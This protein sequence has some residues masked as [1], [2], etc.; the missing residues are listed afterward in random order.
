MAH[1][2]T[3]SARRILSVACA[4]ALI[5]FAA[6]A[7]TGERAQAADGTL[8]TASVSIVTKSQ[9]GLLAARALTVRVR[10]NG[11]GIV[12]LSARA[13]RN[14]QFRSA[15]VS[16]RKAGTRLVRIRLTPRGRADLAACGSQRVRVGWKFRGQKGA[17]GRATSR[18]LSK[19]GQ[20]CFVK[21][22]LGPNPER[23]D[24]LDPSECLQPFANDYFTKADPGT[25]TGRRLN[26]H[27]ESTPA[28][29]K[30]QHIG[31]TDINRADGFSPG[32]MIILKIPGL[33]TPAAFQNS[34]LAPITDTSAWADPE[35]AVMVIDAETGK[36]HPI[37]AELDSNP[38]TIDP[39]DGV[40][41]G[42]NV[43]PSNTDEVNLI[44]RAAKN[45]EY[46]HRYIVA[47]RNL[48]DASGSPI[49]APLA[50][51]V[52][53]DNLPTKQPVVEGRRAHMDSL[54]KTLVNKAGVGRR[55][56]YMAWD[57]TVASRESITGRAL[58]I[59][60]NAFER[61]GDSN[62]SD[63]VISGNSP[64]F[65]ILAV[66]DKDVPPGPGCRGGINPPS[67]EDS[68]PSPGGDVQRVIEGRLLNVPC[69]LNQDGCPP[70]ATFEIKPD[71]TV[72]F[73]P[74]F[75]MRVPFRCFIPESIQPSGEGTPVSPGPA[76]TYGHGLLGDYRQITSAGPVNV[77]REGGGVW[78][79]ANWDGF[80]SA[81]LLTVIDSLADMSNFN[82]AVDRMQQGFVNF[83]MLGRAM[84]HPGGFGTDPAFQLDNL[85]GPGQNL[86]SAIDLSGGVNTRLQYMGISQGG[87][88]G[89]SL[90]ALTPDA[91]RGVLGVPGMNYSL[92]LR[93]SV[94]SDTY[95]K[96]PAFGL[97]KSYPN[98]RD[99]PMILA[100]M[101]LLWDR[102]EP[103]GYAEAMTTD[104]LPDTPPH[105]V[106]MRVAFGD[107]QV[108]NVSAEVEAR[109]IGAGIYSPA[110]NPGR[111]WEPQPF[112]GLELIESFPYGGGPPANGGSIL[113]YYDSGPPSFN[114]S[115]GQGIAT[116]PIQNVPPR[117][118][119]GYGGDPH[120]HPRR[121]A[122]GIRHAVTFL[123][124]GTIQSCA[125]ITPA[126][127]APGDARCYANGWQGPGT[128]SIP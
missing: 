53:R 100:L 71:G 91:D 58:Q 11:K 51:R 104:P 114:G 108:A 5:L 94:D 125:V 120:E 20:R 83:M 28:N 29:T 21:V 42:I 97:Y 61:L 49:P 73:N 72:D 13:K 76:G 102:G 55:S 117:E 10:A 33:D 101:Q 27:P 38:T 75:T 118:E 96:N 8:T 32:N 69:Y 39:K 74:A 62:L 70:G 79:G 105:A 57:F 78:C 126:A 23:C 113:V 87:I 109:T 3:T 66:C 119:W 106:L 67:G 99:R 41:G 43:N 63:R 107:H 14:G 54:I 60:D 88:M 50:F 92:L 59:R 25:K 47:F 110:L 84:I 121:S 40:P 34:G 26:L 68:R 31:V 37:W 93:R 64:S 1:S 128:P 115:E 111:H 19:D 90:M 81:D 46:G 56:L 4:A 2:A 48:K 80:S 112:S 36:R 12:R 24:F 35:Q 124:D 16:F 15:S 86:V 18:T 127:V 123:D 103:N 22:P 30:G 65:E 9:K 44:V 85:A 6:S 89:G 116:P 45:Y 52:Y 98:F 82:K 77:G 7:L 122:D 17:V 95:F